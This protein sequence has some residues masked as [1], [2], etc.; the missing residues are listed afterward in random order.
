MRSEIKGH[1]EMVKETNLAEQV[2]GEIS[3]KAGSNLDHIRADQ[4]FYIVVINLGPGARDHATQIT[5]RATLNFYSYLLANPRLK[6]TIIGAAIHN[7]FKSLADSVT[8][9]DFDG[10]YWPPNELLLGN[11]SI[12][13][14]K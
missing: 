11:A 6:K 9:N 13:E 5:L 3:G 4:E 14:W 8:E 2:F 1:N 10:E 12:T 7:R